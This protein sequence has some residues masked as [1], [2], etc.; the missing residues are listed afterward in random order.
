M[1]VVILSLNT[2]KVDSRAVI[3]GEIVVVKQYAIKQ[4][5]PT[6]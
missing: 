5:G 4:N 1:N 3:L 6:K 2:F